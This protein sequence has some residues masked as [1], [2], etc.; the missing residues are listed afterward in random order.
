MVV[1]LN[2]SISAQNSLSGKITDKETGESL[3][4]VSVYLPDLKTG[5]ISG[6]NGTYKLDHLPN[7]KLLV[8]VSAVGYKLMAESIDLSVVSQK[9]FALDQTAAEL[10]EVVITG[11]SKAAEKNHTPTPIT[12]VPAILLLQNASSNIIDALAKQPGISQITTGST[13]SKPVIRGLGYNRVVTISDGIRQEGQQ[14][15]D[16]HGIE[17]DEYTINRVEILKGPASLAY[18][19]D[20]LAGVINL[21]PAPPVPVGTIK[22]NILTNYQTNNGLI[23]YSADISGNRN[24]IIWNLRYSNKMAHAYQNKYDDYVFNSGFK[25]SAVSGTIGVNKSWGYSHLHLS[26]YN[27]MPGIVEGD[28]DSVTGKFTKLVAI[29]DTTEGKA[30]ATTHDFESYTPVTPFQKIHHYKAVLDNSFILGNGN[31]KAIFGFQQNQRQEYADILN[32]NQ[33]GLYFL[34]NTVTYDLRYILPEYHELSISFGINGMVQNSQNKGTEFLIPEYNLIETGG[35]IIAKKTIDRFDISGGVRFDLHDE[36]SRDLYV[37]AHGEQV[38]NSETGAIHQFTA[39]KNTFSGISS[40]LGATYQFSEKLFTKLNLSRGFRAPNIA[41][42]ASNGI[43]EGTL[44]FVIGVPTLKPEYSL[45]LDYALGLNSKHVSAELDLFSNNISNYIF[46][47]KLESASGGDSITDGYSTF[48]YASGNANLSGGEVTIDIHPHPWDWLHFEN[49]FSYVVAVQKNQPDSTRYLPFT[50]APKL[51]S[52]LKTTA[53]KLGKHLSNAYFKIDLEN[54]FAQNKIYSAFNTETAT[55][56]YTLLNVGLGTDFTRKNRTL[57]SLYVSINN[58]T[59]VAYQ[60]H[61]SR[62]KYADVNHLTGRT[63]VFE[64][65]RNISFKLI[66]PIDLSPENTVM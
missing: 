64:M 46:Q 34:L 38:V 66:I 36:H 13:I 19:S 40:S 28:R 35:F 29:N 22:G 8:H 7:A 12:V 37:N 16:E 50:P 60:S 48:K 58:L 23:G 44:N 47:R 54:Y 41:E 55:A 6:P 3:P 63:G 25:E 65:G 5:A 39:F 24:G 10:N 1:W 32:E 21:L 62:L 20:A 59:D 56:G 61:L 33:Y 43:H 51:T 4:G 27:L 15:G 14:W 52:E 57:F 30:R 18:G 45:Q 9:D 26:A 2:Q 53:K 49:T 31:L 17:V 11:L 42:L